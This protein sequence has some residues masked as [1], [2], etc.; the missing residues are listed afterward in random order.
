MNKSAFVGEWT[1]H[2]VTHYLL[3]RG[4][5]RINPVT[6]YV[7]HGFFAY[8]LPAFIINQLHSLQETRQFSSSEL[9]MLLLRKNKAAYCGRLDSAPSLAITVQF[10]TYFAAKVCCWGAPKLLMVNEKIVHDNVLATV[11]CTMGL[12]LE[13]FDSFLYSLLPCT[14]RCVWL[15]GEWHICAKYPLHSKRFLCLYLCFPSYYLIRPP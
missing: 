11:S 7:S 13:A 10:Q 1:L 9:W 3:G 15:L 8:L 4:A 2:F 12:C 5:V 6:A 14:V